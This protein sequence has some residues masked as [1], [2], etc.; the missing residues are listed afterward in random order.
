MVSF[1]ISLDKILYNYLLKISKE[2]GK[3]ISILIEKLV[4]EY[5]EKQGIKLRK[6]IG[7][8]RFH[9]FPIEENE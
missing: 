4:V 6:E 1:V 8:R 7:R 2:E 5:L 9:Y 3:H